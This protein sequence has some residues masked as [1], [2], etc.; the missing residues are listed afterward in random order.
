M[1]PRHLALSAV[2]LSGPA[3]ADGGNAEGPVSELRL[4]IAAHD[5]RIPGIGPDG[6]PEKSLALQGEVVFRKPR[7]LRPLLSPRPYLAG[8]LNLG[9]HT[10]HAGGGLLWR[11]GFGDRFYGDFAFG[12][13]VHTGALEFPAPTT[14]EAYYRFKADTAQN[15]EF[16]S[17]V[18]F[19]EQFTLG[20]RVDRAWAG[21]LFCEHLS[22]GRIL[23]S[24]ANQ[25]L[26]TVGLRLTRR[27]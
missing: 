17:R 14:P 16:G 19:R 10:S 3:L 22:H 8:S 23:S 25:G 6:R 20:M 13:V 26:D 4:G 27:F 9:G 5:I 11:Q 2:L 18:L 21:G 12:A 15:I 24:R 1:K 7:L